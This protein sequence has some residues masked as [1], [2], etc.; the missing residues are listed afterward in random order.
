[1]WSTRRDKRRSPIL[2]LCSHATLSAWLFLS[3]TDKVKKTTTAICHRQK[4]AVDSYRLN[5]IGVLLKSVLSSIPENT[6]KRVAV[7][8]IQIKAFQQ[9]QD[10]MQPSVCVQGALN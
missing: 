10:I 2:L 5:L 4:A 9:K 6:S 7:P 3:D 8:N 1:M